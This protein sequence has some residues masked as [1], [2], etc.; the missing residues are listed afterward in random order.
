MI[1]TQTVFQ[2]TDA[3]EEAHERPGCALP[4]AYRALLACIGAP[5]SLDAIEAR[6]AHCSGDEVA[7]Y[8]EDLEAIGLIES[9][10]PQWLEALYAVLSADLYP[11][12]PSA[13]GARQA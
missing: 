12:A 9:V 7:R 3:G 11:S 13:A 6:L 1:D 10:S 8:L 4:P 2:R 5:T